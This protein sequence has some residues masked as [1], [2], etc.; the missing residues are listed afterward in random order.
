MRLLATQI[1]LLRQNRSVSFSAILSEFCGNAWVLPGL[2]LFCKHLLCCFGR[3]IRFCLESVTPTNWVGWVGRFW[4][5]FWGILPFWGFW[6][7]LA[8]GLF[9]GGALFWEGSLDTV[10]EPKRNPC[11]VPRRPEKTREDPKGLSRG[12]KCIEGGGRIQVVFRSQRGRYQV[13]LDSISGPGSVS[14]LFQ[15]VFRSVSGRIV[16]GDRPPE[17]RNEVEI[18]SKSGRNEVELRSGMSTVWTPCSREI[19]V[20]SPRSIL[21]AEKKANPL[22]S[23]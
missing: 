5:G 10:F 7:W 2:Y 21:V 12:T 17:G 1:N 11:H 19:P 13:A 20:R 9:G 18:R 4:G 22:A 23:F 16:F 8:L 14:G 3:G 15:V 6:A